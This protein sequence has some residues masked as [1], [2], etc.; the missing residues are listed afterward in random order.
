MVL[1]IANSKSSKESL[2]IF[3]VEMEREIIM[4]LADCDN[5]LPQNHFLKRAKQYLRDT[6]NTRLVFQRFAFFSEEAV[7][8]QLVANFNA[9]VPS[10]E[11]N[12]KT[13]SPSPRDYYLEL[14]FIVKSI[15]NHEF[16]TYIEPLDE[17]E[18]IPSKPDALIDLENEVLHLMAIQPKL[19]V[20]EDNIST[21]FDLLKFQTLLKDGQFDEKCLI[22]VERMGLERAKILEEVKRLKGER[23]TSVDEPFL[24]ALEA[25]DL[26][27]IQAFVENIDRYNHFNYLKAAV[28][29]NN[30]AVL[31]CLDPDLSIYIIF[32]DSH[33]RTSINPNTPPERLLKA[34]N[35]YEKL[36]QYAFDLGNL[37]AFIWAIEKA[38]NFQKLLLPYDLLYGHCIYNIFS[39]YLDKAVSRH[40]LPLISYLVPNAFN[41]DKS[42]DPSVVEIN[43]TF[44]EYK[45]K[46]L[47]DK[48]YLRHMAELMSDAVALK[49]LQHE[50][51]EQLTFR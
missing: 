43:T 17:Y 15:V 19:L 20:S 1:K 28:A 31:N 18:I 30:V 32:S 6:G 46:L 47:R 14:C 40:M 36:A 4:R 13:F 24:K 12:G 7:E 23:I 44:E 10:F 38:T 11:F 45:N 2:T 37:D 34:F 3:P 8:Q 26:T 29:A 27:G 16:N 25:N 41:I 49:T 48:P 50:E 9:T 39:H 33:L 42:Y 51:H 22:L 5:P 35:S 21:L